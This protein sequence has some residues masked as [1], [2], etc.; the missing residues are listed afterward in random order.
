[1]GLPALHVHAEYVW[2]GGWIGVSLKANAL[3]SYGIWILTVQHDDDDD[4]RTFYFSPNPS[5]T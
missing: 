1:M 4:D 3:C 5:R 2:V